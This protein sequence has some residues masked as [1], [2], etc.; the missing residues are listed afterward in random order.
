MGDTASCEQMFVVKQSGF[1]AKLLQGKIPR[2]ARSEH[3]A[4]KL[5]G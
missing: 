3:G 2:L 5:V 1:A 4:T